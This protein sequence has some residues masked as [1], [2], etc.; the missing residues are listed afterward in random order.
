MSEKASPSSTPSS[1]AQDSRNA[2]DL[3]RAQE[4]R[5]KQPNGFQHSEAPPS[6]EAK[7]H[8]SEAES[9]LAI[10]GS[11]SPSELPPKRNK[12]NPKTATHPGE[13]ES[14]FSR[15]P[16]IRVSTSANG[17]TRGKTESQPKP[18]ASGAPVAA[19]LEQAQSS[20]SGSGLNKDSGYSSATHNTSHSP[21]PS[22]SDKRDQGA[23]KSSGWLGWWKSAWNYLGWSGGKIQCRLFLKMKEGP[24]WWLLSFIWGTIYKIASALPRL[25]RLQPRE[26]LLKYRVIINP[27]LYQLPPDLKD[28]IAKLQQSAKRELEGETLAAAVPIQRNLEDAR[29]LALT[30]LGDLVEATELL[31][32]YAR[33]VPAVETARP[34]KALPLAPPLNIG[35]AM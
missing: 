8:P 6:Q 31:A 32:D 18:I 11:P 9:T 35:K 26:P 29:K 5:L 27:T 25:P 7:Q 4:G 3:K 10:K 34:K 1:R 12:S 28:T 15:H 2:D 33:A 19:D 22:L 23:S 13:S 17:R 16:T 21:R 30:F 20:S 24:Q 14:P